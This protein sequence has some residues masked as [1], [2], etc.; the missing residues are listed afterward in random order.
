MGAAPTVLRPPTVT[1]ACT[2]AVGR[3]RAS[4]LVPHE[5]R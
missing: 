4:N 1:G 2:A 5:A 3:Y